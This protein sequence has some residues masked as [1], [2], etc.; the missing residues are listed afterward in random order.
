MLQFI[1]VLFLKGCQDSI[2]K[3]TLLIVTFTYEIHS[4]T[5]SIERYKIYDMNCFCF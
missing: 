1:T 4:Q 2:T 3:N 5:A